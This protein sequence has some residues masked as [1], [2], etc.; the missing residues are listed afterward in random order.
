[1][2]ITSIESEKYNLICCLHKHTL[3]SN[4]DVLIMDVLIDRRRQNLEA[5]WGHYDRKKSTFDW[6]M[7]AL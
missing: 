5:I 2:Y 3:R 4:V 6:C 1:M 7:S